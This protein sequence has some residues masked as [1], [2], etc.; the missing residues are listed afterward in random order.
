M[1]N[2]NSLTA[3][4]FEQFSQIWYFSTTRWPGILDFFTHNAGNRGQGHKCPKLDV[5]Y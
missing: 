3:F 5:T 1:A 2:F 4:I